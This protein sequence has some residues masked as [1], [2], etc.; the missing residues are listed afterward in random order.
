MNKI[1]V[2]S[3]K[4]EYCSVEHHTIAIDGIPL[5]IMLHSQYP[6]DLLLGMIPTII[7]WIDSPKEKELL[8]GRFNSVGKEVSLPVLMCPDDCD[9]FCT[10]IVANVVKAGGRIIWK[11]IGIDR[12]HEE[13]KLL[14]CDGIGSRVDWLEKIPPMTFVADQYYSQLSKIYD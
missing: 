10:V 4:S 13:I 3:M 2:V 1:E 14:R 7:D 6:T 8:K 9:L 11:K 12:S 5:D